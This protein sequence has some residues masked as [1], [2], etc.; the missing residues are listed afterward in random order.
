ML[1]DH[2]VQGG[3][4]RI[5][6]CVLDGGHAGIGAD[7]MPSLRRPELCRRADRATPCAGRCVRRNSRPW[8]ELRA[9]AT[10]LCQRQA[11]QTKHLVRFDVGWV[12]RLKLRVTA[13]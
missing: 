1:P 13:Q 4:T 3:G 2:G 8:Q 5:A 11:G 6:W 10:Q 9:S 7:D 12:S